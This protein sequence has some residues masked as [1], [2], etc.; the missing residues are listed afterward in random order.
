[1]GVAA[2]GGWVLKSATRWSF[3][4]VAVGI[5]A[6]A[7]VGFLLARSF[8]R[9]NSSTALKCLN[10]L[11]LPWAVYGVALLVAP[12]RLAVPA[13]ASI[14]EAGVWLITVVLIV[15]FGVRRNADSRRAQP[16]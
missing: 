10:G 13:T 7:A 8:R 11:A 12:G 5:L 2:F 6:F 4:P 14:L 1:M 16:L 9:S 15:A 3:L